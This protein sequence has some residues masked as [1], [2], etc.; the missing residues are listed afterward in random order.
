MV[1]LNNLHTKEYLKELYDLPLEDK[2]IVSQ[3]LIKEW[4]D[5]FDG[6]VY[7]SFSGGKDSTVLKHLVGNTLGVRDVTSIFI[8]TGLEYPEIIKFV[9]SQPNV[10]MVYPQMRFDEVI[11]KYGYPVISKEVADCIHGARLSL[12]KGADSARLQ[13]M[14]GRF[15]DKDGEKSPYNYKKYEYLLDA[16]FE[17]SPYCCNIMKK[18]PAKIYEK[19]SKRKPYLGITV[20]E[21]FQRKNN[22]LRYGCNAFEN[23]RQYSAPLS[24]WS[25]NDILQYIS[26][27]QIPYADCYGEIKQDENGNYYTTGLKRTGCM[28]CMFGVHLE[29]EPNRFQQMKSTHPAQYDFCINKLGIGKVLDYIKVKY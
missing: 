1:L 5:Y 25:E 10:E 15:K 26:D 9:V 8:N 16:L 11:K 14:Q 27:K 17:I 7:I 24:F 21:S 13:K 19:E 12:E 20:D 28:F 23:K 2:I 18:K 3:K 6:A 29:K 4:Y 22:W